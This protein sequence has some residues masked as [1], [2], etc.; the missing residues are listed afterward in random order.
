LLEPAKESLHPYLPE[1]DIAHS[2]TADRFR[3]GFTVNWGWRA[4][5]VDAGVVQCEL[6]PRRYRRRAIARMIAKMGLGENARAI[7]WRDREF[8]VCL[9]VTGLFASD[10]QPMEMEIDALFRIDAS[11][12]MRSTLDELTQ[13]AEEISKHITAKITLM[14]QQWVAGMPAEEFYRQEGKLAAWSDIAKGWVQEALQGSAFDVVRITRLRI[15]SPVLDQLYKEYGAMAME[16][17]EARREV[18]RNKVRG[19]L[20]QAIQ[21]GKLDEIRDQAEHENAVRA[22]EQERAL[23]DRA[24]RQELAQEEVAAL[25]VRLK[26][27]K[28]KH[29]LL[30]R[31]LDAVPEGAPATGD[32]V[33]RVAEILGRATDNAADSPFSAQER[34][35]I[36]TILQSARSQASRPDEILAAV[37]KGG[38]IPCALFDPIAGIRGAHTLHIGDGWKIFD[39]ASLYQIRLTRIMTRRHGF[40]WHRESPSR[41]H[42]DVRGLP[43]KRQFSQDVPLDTKFEIAV[44][45]HAVPV[46]YLG[47]TPSRISVRIPRA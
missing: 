28:R 21:A 30:L 31:T 46:E 35:Q 19:A 32:P 14:S 42:F 10:H 33:Q 20:R 36:R 13:P 9:Y 27:W 3:R 43:E 8:P 23:K 4:A 22:I 11:R 12:L 7:V 29:E 15:F 40:L 44:G 17:E 1:G 2:Y 45:P 34:E 47:G 5:L 39:G 26:V 16:S 37:A 38:D 25:E 41:A 6:E 24:L 18:E